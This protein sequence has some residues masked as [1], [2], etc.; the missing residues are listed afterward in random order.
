MIEKEFRVNEY[1]TV[2]LDGDKTNIFIKGRKFQKCM[3]PAFNITK[4]KQGNLDETQSIDELQGVNW[5]NK[6]EESKIN[7]EEVFWVVCS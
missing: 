1:I 4:E 7:P 3:Y 6:L 5:T 2:R